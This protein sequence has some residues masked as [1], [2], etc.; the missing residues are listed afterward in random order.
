L[1]HS[2]S[3]PT[4]ST[5]LRHHHILMRSYPH[6]RCPSH[7][8]TTFPSTG[9]TNVSPYANPSD[10][11][12]MTSIPRSHHPTGRMEG[13]RVR[14]RMGSRRMEGAIREKSG[15][16]PKTGGR[17]QQNE[18]G[19]QEQNGGGDQQHSNEDGEDKESGD[20][21][22]ES[23]VRQRRSEV[24]GQASKP[25]G[26]RSLLR[27]SDDNNPW[28]ESYQKRRELRQKSGHS[29]P[30]IHTPPSLTPRQERQGIPVKVYS[31]VSMDFSFSFSIVFIQHDTEIGRG[32]STFVTPVRE[33]ER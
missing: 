18:D 13:M 17:K 16:K 33:L 7:S 28:S 11:S 2:C 15:Q 23:S 26:E 10:P 5:L 32:R 14:V 31:Q 4:F 29:P 12:G 30:K 3:V 9:Y 25:E 24:N 1:F 22:T 19:E 21:S 20:R 27:H 8:P 6:S